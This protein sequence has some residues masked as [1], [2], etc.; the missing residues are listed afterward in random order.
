M[1]SF[2]VV[3]LYVFI[4][5]RGCSFLH[6][7]HWPYTNKVR[8]G[9]LSGTL[10]R[11]R[12]DDPFFA[13][14]SYCVLSNFNTVTRQLSSLAIPQMEVSS[15]AQVLKVSHTAGMET[16]SDTIFSPLIMLALLL[17]SL[18]HYPTNHSV[19]VIVPVKRF[20]LVLLIGTILHDS[21]PRCPV[22]YILVTCPG[23]IPQQCT[24]D[25]HSITFPKNMLPGTYIYWY[26][27]KCMPIII[28]P[29]F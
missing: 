13:Q 3:I 12:Q 25:Y 11:C 16:M 29:Q 19:V 27:C 24:C 2:T 15:R 22:S 8:K 23:F 4:P 9:C 5:I 14:I 21:T 26:L 10:H 6:I 7:F 18:H 17:Q 1:C 28:S 20:I